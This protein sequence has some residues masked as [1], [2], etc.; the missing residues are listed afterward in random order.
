M[1]TSEQEC[2]EFLNIFS[3]LAYKANDV[4]AFQKL[5]NYSLL[6]ICDSKM[7]FNRDEVKLSSLQLVCGLVELG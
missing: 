2:S 5:V 7:I 3:F 6:D 4:E 1:E